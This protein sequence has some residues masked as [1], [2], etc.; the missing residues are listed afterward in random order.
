MMNKFILPELRDSQGAQS[1]LRFA[2]ENAQPKLYRRAHEVSPRRAGEVTLPELR[3][4]LMR[5]PEAAAACKAVSEE[6]GKR[7]EAMMADN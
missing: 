2:I 3:I 1:S 6:T 7:E 5:S 4:E